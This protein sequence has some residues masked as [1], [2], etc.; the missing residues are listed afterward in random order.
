MVDEL[1]RRAREQLEVP[2]DDLRHRRVLV[3]TLAELRT[4]PPPRRPVTWIVAT[5]VAVAAAVVVWFVAAGSRAPAPTVVDETPAAPIA[6]VEPAPPLVEPVDPARI[7]LVDGTIVRLGPAAQIETERESLVHVE[8]RQSAGEVHYTVPELAGREVVVHAATI[9]IMVAAAEFFVDVGVDEVTIRVER[10]SVQVR[11]ADRDVR[12]GAGERATLRTTAASTEVLPKKPAAVRSPARPATREHASAD[13][14]LRRADEARRA[15]RFDD[16]ATALETILREHPRDPQVAAALFTL[17][18]V[19]R[20][21]GRHVQAA[22]AFEACWR[23]RE[24]GPL[25]GDALGSAAMEYQQAGRHERAVELARLY[26]ARLPA[27]LHAAAM[28]EILR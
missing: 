17:G 7:V 27:G 8:L 11:S 18:R 19:E 23:K 25:A 10:G 13:E 16:A 28:Y 14:L 6:A 4:S 3:R 20:A 2:W 21:R 22:A 24:R 5:T 1:A 15:G 26:V 12:L 9:T